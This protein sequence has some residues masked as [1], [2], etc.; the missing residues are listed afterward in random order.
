MFWHYV[1]CGISHHH[2]VRL[3]IIIL[4]AKVMLFL[5]KYFIKK[6]KIIIYLSKK[7][8]LIVI[9]TIVAEP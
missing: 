3:K 6:S 7:N 5:I 1:A 9:L 8:P 4:V 2:V